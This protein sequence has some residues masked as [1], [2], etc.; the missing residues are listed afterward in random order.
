[1]YSGF[2]TFEVQGLPLQ[3]PRRIAELVGCHAQRDPNVKWHA[4]VA[5]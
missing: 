3:T 4:K 2:G 1:M 5:Y